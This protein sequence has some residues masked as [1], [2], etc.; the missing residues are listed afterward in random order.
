MRKLGWFIMCSIMILGS[1]TVVDGQFQPG[2]GFGGFGGGGQQT[3][4]NV[5]NRAD[6]KKE[7]D[8]TDEQLAKLPAEVLVAIS[9][10]LN[11]KQFSRFKQIELQNRKNNVFKDAAVQTALSMTAEQKKSIGS[12][13]DDEAK[14]IAELQPKFGKGGGGD[15][16]GALEKQNN[17]RKESKEK[18][19][20]VLTKDQRKTFRELVGDEFKFTQG[21][22]GGAKKANPKKDAE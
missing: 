12:I 7:L 10:V 13:L 16:K 4:L 21:F 3:P 20:T 5:L 11:D 8:I 22:G 17:V 6:V 1:V 15:F 18:I 2:G 9:K 19:Y 14:E